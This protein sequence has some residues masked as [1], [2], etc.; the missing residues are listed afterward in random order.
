MLANFGRGIV[1][2]PILC[3]NNIVYNLVIRKRQ[4]DEGM[5]FGRAYTF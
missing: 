3:Y 5:Y 1:L 2:L 4:D